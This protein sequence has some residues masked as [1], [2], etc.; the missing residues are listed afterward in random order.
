V[1]ELEMLGFSKEIEELKLQKLMVLR[2]RT[3]CYKLAKK[4]T[5][6]RQMVQQ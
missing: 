1:G 2:E 6:S 3:F 4:M 5:T